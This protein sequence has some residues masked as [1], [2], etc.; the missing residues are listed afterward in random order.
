MTLPQ[1]KYHPDPVATQSVVASSATCDCCGQA[2][3]YVY[4]G[5]I[6]AQEEPAGPICPWCI[7]DGFAHT[8][9]GADFSDWDGIGGY[10]EWDE[11]PTDVLEEVA[12]RTPGFRSVQQAQWWTHCGDAAEYLGIEEDRV[13]FRCRRCGEMGGYEDVD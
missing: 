2:R 4:D 11:V 10:G 8:K 9:Y 12:F 7:A 5:P 1:F 13:R 6:Y 3:G